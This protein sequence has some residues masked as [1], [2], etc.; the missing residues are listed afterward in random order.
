MNSLLN[1]INFVLL[2][3]LWRLEHRRFGCGCLLAVLLHW[4]WREH[5]SYINVSM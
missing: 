4:S 5:D 1:S 2:L 3:N